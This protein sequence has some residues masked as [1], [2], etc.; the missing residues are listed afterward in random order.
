MAQKKITIFRS[1]NNAGAVFYDGNKKTDW[2][3]LTAQEQRDLLVAMES[4]YS[5][6][7]RFLKE[8]K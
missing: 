3:N 4:I 5:L 2:A 1:G 6:M 7:R 8:D